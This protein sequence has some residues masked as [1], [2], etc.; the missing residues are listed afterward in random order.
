MNDALRLSTRSQFIS[1]QLAS[2]SGPKRE[3]GD[4]LFISCPFHSE[5]TPSGKVDRER[6]TFYCFGCG[7]KCS[8]DELAA[9]IGLQPFIK[10]KPKDET[11]TDLF[12]QKA[13]ALLKNEQ[14]FVQDRLRFTAIPKNKVWRSISTNLLIDLGGRLCIKYSKEYERWGSTKFIHFPVIVNKEQ[15][16]YFLARLK[17]HPDYP[18]YMLASASVNQKWVLSRGL[19]PFDYS[20]ELMKNLGSTS[21]VLVEGQ[22]D[23]L[24]LI[25]SGIPAL[26]IFGTQS[27]SDKKAQLLEVA[28]VTKLIILMDGDDA[29]IKASEKIKDRASSLLNVAEIKLWNIKGSPYLEFEDLAEPSKTAKLKGVELWDP[30]N[31]PQWI[32]DKLKFKYF[33]K[34]RE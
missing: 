30:C 20:L 4:R 28:G 19:W 25:L 29:G 34:F 7:A 3:Q 2:Y 16:G 11:S 24:R 15:C 21:M 23:A 9:K 14:P 33:H 31:A 32:I 13:L 12:M 6:G 17:K 1:S 27:W 5:R 22:R 18:S 10:G 26:C 8:W